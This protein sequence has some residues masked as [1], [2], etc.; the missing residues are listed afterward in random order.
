MQHLNKVVKLSDG[1]KHIATTKSDYSSL[2]MDLAGTSLTHK[3]TR[4]RLSRNPRNKARPGR[5]TSTKR[6]EQCT[7]SDIGSSNNDDSFDDA[8]GS[9]ED[10]S[11]NKSASLSHG[12]NPGGNDEAYDS[13]YASEKDNGEGLQQWPVTTEDLTLGQR[14]VSVQH[15]AWSKRMGSW[16]ADDPDDVFDGGSCAHHD[17]FKDGKLQGDMVATRSALNKYCNCVKTHAGRL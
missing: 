12:A 16:G 7:S 14:Q 13:G 5:H 10:V 17:L 4:R 3:G 6:H 11:S 1:S 15:Q 9:R 8:I 2:S